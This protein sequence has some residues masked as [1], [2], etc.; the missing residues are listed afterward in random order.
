MEDDG[1]PSCLR[2]NGESGRRRDREVAASE[3]TQRAATVKRMDYDAGGGMRSL[4]VVPW[5]NAGL[6]G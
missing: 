2:G 5:H 6:Y 1:R 3:R 4:L